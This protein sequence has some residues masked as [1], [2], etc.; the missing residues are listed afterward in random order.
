MGGVVYDHKR[1][2]DHCCQVGL[3]AVIADLWGKAATDI[4]S[5]LCCPPEQVPMVFP[6]TIIGKT[7]C[8]SDDYHQAHPET[9]DAKPWGNAATDIG[10][11][12]AGRPL[13]QAPLA[14]P[15]V[16]I[17]ESALLQTL[18]H[19]DGSRRSLRWMPWAGRLTLVE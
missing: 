8:F 12:I 7:A 11:S 3:V 6:L 14:T 16:V 1:I 13:E 15:L 2:R 19:A 18:I 17:G 5:Y 10:A 4:V 9:C